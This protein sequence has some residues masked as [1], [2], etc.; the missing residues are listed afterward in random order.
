MGKLILKKVK[1]RNL[2]VGDVFIAESPNGY[3]REEM[4]T[5][6]D[7]TL[8][9]DH[10]YIKTIKITSWGERIDNYYIGEDLDVEVYTVQIK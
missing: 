5:K 1:L 6:K 3:E 9:H 10:L 4:I 8:L 2:L 7:R